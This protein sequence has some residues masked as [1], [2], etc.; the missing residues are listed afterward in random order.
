[1]QSSF[2]LPNLKTC[3][4]GM[5][6]QRQTLMCFSYIA[7]QPR[8]TLHTTPHE[9]NL[10]TGQ[11]LCTYLM[12]YLLLNVALWLLGHK[13]SPHGLLEL[14]L[15]VLSALHIFNWWEMQKV[16]ELLQY[17]L[18]AWYGENFPYRS[19]VLPTPLVMSSTRSLELLHSQR[20]AVY[21]PWGS[22]VTRIPARLTIT[23]F[24]F[25]GLPST[26]WPFNAACMIS[27]E[28]AQRRRLR[29]TLHKMPMYCLTSFFYQYSADC[30]TTGSMCRCMQV[31]QEIGS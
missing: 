14:L 18:S 21:E 27:A 15:W 24:A 10:K 9:I 29:E 3:M 2:T 28:A 1:M 4:G 31:D 13:G 30:Y 6:A 25:S 12:Q 11:V 17:I 22:D 23:T 16:L 7:L 8:A 20:D 26:A 5:R 19:I